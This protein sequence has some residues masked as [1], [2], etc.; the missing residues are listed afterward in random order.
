M[1]EPA[2]SSAESPIRLFTRETTRS[3]RYA[4]IGADPQGASRIWFALHGYGQLADRFLR[5]FDGIVPADTCVIA[6]EG[7]S[8]FYLEAPRADGGHMQRVGASWLTR[9]QRELEIVDAMT[10]L[11]QVHDEVVSAASRAT[12]AVPWT[13][14]LGFSQGVATAMRW[15]ASGH[16]APSHVV[17]WAGGL[18]HDADV[19]ALR[20]KLAHADLTLVCGDED[21]FATVEARERMLAAARELHPSP[22][23]ILFAGRHQL[24]VDVLR[25]ILSRAKT[26]PANPPSANV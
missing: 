21:Q 2:A 26:P 6:P 10:W 15:I 17:V 24:D 13:G 14:V 18:A 9:E 25:S 8:R 5:P 3:A 4:A 12:G 20:A 23:E 1:S 11:D 19:T 7:L 16:V 22:R